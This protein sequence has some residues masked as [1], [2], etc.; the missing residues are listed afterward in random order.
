MVSTGGA[1]RAY[2]SPLR[3][4]RAAAN[5]RRIIESAA[6]A[7]SARGHAGT[8]LAQIAAGAGVS[9]ESV[10]DLGNKAYLLIEAFRTRYAGFGEW[11]SIM[12]LQWAR[13]I[14]QIED[15]EEGLDVTIDFF[16]DAH[17]RSADLWLALRATALVE[18]LV[19]EA[20]AELNQFK[21][22]NWL[23]SIEWM[24]RIGIIEAEIRSDEHD[25][26]AASAHVVTSAETYVQ[27]M[28]D[29]GLTDADYRDWLRR[30]IP[31]LRP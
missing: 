15:P 10:Q 8:T 24:V 12:E 29:W 18:P 23:E 20:F 17:A 16:S 9:V 22:E 3:A 2:N 5:R 4:E 26:L 25:R 13:D 11:N 31:A 7:F 6:D 14:M 1:K 21:R 27:L 28:R 30:A 19:A